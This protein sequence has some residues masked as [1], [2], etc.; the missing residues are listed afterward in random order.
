LMGV[1]VTD[2]TTE[3]FVFPNASYYGFW[4]RVTLR[5]TTHDEGGLTRRDFALARAI[6]NRLKT[7]RSPR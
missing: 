5:I 3:L 1:N 2:T 4:T 6:E 7:S